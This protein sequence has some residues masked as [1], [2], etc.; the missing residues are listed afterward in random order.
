MGRPRAKARE[1]GGLNLTLRCFFGRGE[2]P[3]V[4]MV[5]RGGKSREGG[6]WI[7]V[8]PK[9]WGGVLPLNPT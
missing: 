8:M 1:G 5:G 7:F 3:V 4:V 2:T 9:R 6:D